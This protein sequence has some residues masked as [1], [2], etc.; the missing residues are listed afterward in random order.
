MYK[1]GFGCCVAQAFYRADIQS[2]RCGDE[3]G[4]RRERIG[5]ISGGA[6]SGGEFAGITTFAAGWRMG[7]VHRRDERRAQ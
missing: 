5:A 4:A 6:I 3:A 1:L 2:E 7:A